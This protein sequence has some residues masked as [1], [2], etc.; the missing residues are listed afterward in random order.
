MARYL[1]EEGAR[2]HTGQH[3][4]LR[5]GLERLEDLGF[6]LA[7][8]AAAYGIEPDELEEHYRQRNVLKVDGGVRYSYPR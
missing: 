6:F 4:E 5:R 1:A 3:G 8:G 7:L 2:A